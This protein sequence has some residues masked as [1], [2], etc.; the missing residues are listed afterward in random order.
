[1]I[2]MH[3]LVTRFF[4]KSRVER[5]Y[6]FFAYATTVFFSLIVAIFPKKVILKR[7][8]VL[9]AESNQ[10]IL[11]GKHEIV[12][13][14]AKAIRRTVRYTPWNVT[15]FAKAIAAKYLLKRQG[16]QSTLYLGVAKEND[17]KLTAHAWLRCGNIIVTGKEEMERFT[18][19]AYFT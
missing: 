11:E 15:C 12:E 10:D 19:V 14:I 1:M 7:I 3:G 18:A 4:Q 13:Q 9:G 2:P 8:G 5:R 17:N 16:L 6:F